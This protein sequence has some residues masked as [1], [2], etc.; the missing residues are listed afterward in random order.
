[1]EVKVLR[2][3]DYGALVEIE[4]GIEGLIHV[5]EMADERVEDPHTVVKE[6]ET[7]KA[8]VVNVDIIERRINLSMK[9]AKRSSE[10]SDYQPFL[11]GGKPTT[12]LGDLLKE[13]LEKKSKRDE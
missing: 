12:S 13:K 6:G 9:Q 3:H 1:M 5:S 8:E 2:V 10:R 11:T 7:V 4:K